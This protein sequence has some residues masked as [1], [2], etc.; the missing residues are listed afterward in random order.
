MGR[1]IKASLAYGYTLGGDDGGWEF[2]EVYGDDEYE[3][4]YG[5]KLDWYDSDDEGGEGFQEQAMT[6]LLATAGFTETDW[7]ADGYYERR[8]EAEKRLGVQFERT[9]YEGGDLLLI[10]RQEEEFDAYC[11]DVEEIDPGALTAVGNADADALLAA[12]L[13]ALGITPNQEKAAWLLTVYYG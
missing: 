10:V 8:W 5:P 3:Q 1:T 11:G 12:A 7:R 9:G 2:H 4:G 13:Q 6:R